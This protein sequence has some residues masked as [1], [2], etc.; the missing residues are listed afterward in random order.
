M[1]ARRT[2]EILEHQLPDVSPLGEPAFMAVSELCDNAM[3][4][5]RNAVGSYVAVQRLTEPRRQVSVAVGDLGIGIPEHI[6]QRYPEWSDDSAAI[7]LATEPGK[8]GTDRPH[9]GIGFS[10]VME[11]ALTASL[12]AA[13]MD[14]HS[15]TGF[16]R[17]QVVQESQKPEVFPA[18]NYRRGTWIIYDLV[19][20]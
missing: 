7:A 9:R 16:F 1:T 8:T 13:K 20:V 6:R 4:H 10:A 12:H 17:L 14:I 3:D 15:A 2:Q 18:S 19:S 5:G 11:A